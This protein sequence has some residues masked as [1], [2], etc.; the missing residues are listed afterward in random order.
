MTNRVRPISRNVIVLGWVSFFNDV[1]SEMLYPIIPLFLVGTLGASPAIL[2]LVEGIAEGGSS[3]LRWVAGALSDRFRRRKPFVVI[4]YALSAISKPVMGLAAT[5]IGWPLFLLGRSTDRLGKS[6]RTSARDALIADSTEPQYR[7][8]AFGL[9]RAM[10]TCGAIVGPLVALGFIA[11]AQS[12]SLAWLF[13]VALAPGILSAIVALVAVRDIPHEAH[14]G[15]RPPPIFQRFSGR[16]W[17]LIAAVTLFSLGNSSDSFLLLRSR[18]V[19]LSLSSVILA[20][21]LY[22]VVY[23]LG[24][25]PLGRLS[26]RIGRKPV[27][28]A[29]WVV[30]A[31]VYFGFGAARSVF[32]PWLLLAAYGIYQAMT[33]GVTK[34]L[35]ADIVPKSQRAGAI[36]LFY[37][38]TGMAQ[39]AASLAA[40]A[41][42]NVRLFH[43][44]I[45]ATFLMGTLCSV[46]AV[47]LMLGLRVAE[48]SSEG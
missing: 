15:A 28:V 43:G 42:W 9:H 17:H 47:P 38:A 18:Q 41:L 3:V 32:A 7:G 8:R 31:A 12:R 6:I 4:G 33:D 14:P 13:V 24:A 40:G 11:A 16:F 1:A 37:T 39:L 21:V 22:N 2:G 45:M 10:D 26:D 29:G 34:A 5:A 36:G 23:A 48:V 46:A 25:L 19:G 44:T 35:V 27:V 30:Y 20:Y